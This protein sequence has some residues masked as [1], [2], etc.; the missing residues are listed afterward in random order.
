MAEFQAVGVYDV[1]GMGEQGT[2]EGVLG[3]VPGF[4]R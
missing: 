1:M 2:G 3:K 4:A